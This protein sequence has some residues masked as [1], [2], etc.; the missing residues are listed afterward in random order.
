MNTKIIEWSARFI[1]VRARADVQ[2][3]RWYVAL[4]V[5]R[6]IRVTA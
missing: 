1:H 3:C 5:N 4:T 6:P 2:M